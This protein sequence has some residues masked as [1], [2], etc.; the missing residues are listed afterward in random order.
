MTAETAL[1]CDHNAT[2]P[3]SEAARSAM[4]EALGLVGNPH[5]PHGPGRAAAARVRTARRQVCDLL[6]CAPVQLC[7]TSGATEANATV[8]TGLRSAARPRVLCSAVE[9]PSVRAWADD[10]I[11]VHPDGRLDLEQLDRLLDRHGHE[12]AVVSVMAANN[13]TGVCFELAPV[14][15]RCRAAGVPLHVDATQAPGRIPLGPLARADPRTGT[16]HKLGG[17]KGIGALV[18]RG[19]PPA[20]LLRGGPQERGQR[21]GTVNV[22]AVAGFGAA[23][24]AVAAAPL[25]SPATRDAVEAAAVALGARV[26][27]A[28]SPRLPNTSCLVFDVP[29]EL[30]V[31]GLDLEGVSASTGSACA[32]GAAEPSH[33]LAAMGI[34]DRPLRLSFGPDSS[35][36]PVIAALERVVA[37]VRGAMGPGAA[38]S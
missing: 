33:V 15:A 9:H 38:F 32:S 10:E 23:A 3:L 20:S 19:T 18:M 13:E 22:A 30:L 25:C 34:P 16:A 28:S 4:I 14:A 5:S 26:V 17:P 12:L 1:Y 8:L 31:M 36:G 21:A 29:G 6:G 7:F 37:R 35:A 2:A 24:A 27:G 11:P